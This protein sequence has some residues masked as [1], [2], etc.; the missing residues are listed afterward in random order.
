MTIRLNQKTGRWEVFFK[1]K[2]VYSHLSLFM[3]EAYARAIRD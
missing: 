2:K 1:S 3:A